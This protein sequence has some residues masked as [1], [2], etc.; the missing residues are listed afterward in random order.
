ML[1]GC[2]VLRALASARWEGGEGRSANRLRLHV[3][4]WVGALGVRQR[5]LTSE[6]RSCGFAPERRKNPKTAQ[7]R[8]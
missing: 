8:E 1:Q 6:G 2:G 4:A 3:G 5:Q 7:G